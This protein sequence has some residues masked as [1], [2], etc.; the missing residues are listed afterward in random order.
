MRE[1]NQPHPGPIR[2]E[3]ATDPDLAD[4]VVEFVASLHEHATALREALGSGDAASIARRSHQ[5]K[6]SGS[7]YGFHQIG[8]SAG[9]VERNARAVLGGQGLESLRASV[10]ELI[11][12][13]A[14]ARA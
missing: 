13:C 4:L 9:V 12:L 2:S 11:D 3:F 14:R 10:D 1:T 6:G 7:G 8:V 5:I